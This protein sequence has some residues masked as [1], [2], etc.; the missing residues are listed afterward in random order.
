[1]KLP[2]LVSALFTIA[3]LLAPA[4]AHATFYRSAPSST[5]PG[6]VLQE[7]NRLRANPSAYADY[8]ET[9]RPLYRADKVLDMHLGTIPIRTHE[10]VAALDEAIR[11]LRHTR[12]LP[13]LSYSSGLALSARDHA[14]EQGRTGGIGHAGRG[15][16][17]PFNRMDRYGV[18]CNEAGEDIAYGAPSAR[19]VVMN[20]IVDDGIPGR[21]HRTSLLKPTFGVAGI[22]VGT[23]PLYG[24]VCV[25][26]L[27]SQFVAR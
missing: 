6:D 19:Q 8:L 24:A 5:L 26:D 20:L 11:C 9:L 1:M 23:H 14:L 7:I 22:G 27:A 2:P 25:I 13:P 17:N 16:S 21:G 3:F 10:G 12:P 18:W 15:G 4:A